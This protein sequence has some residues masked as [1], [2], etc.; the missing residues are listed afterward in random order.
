MTLSIRRL[1]VSYARREVLHSLS[2]SLEEGEITALIGPNGAGKSTLIKAVSGVVPSK[3]EIFAGGQNLQ[4]VSRRA[5]A[6]L[7]AVV[8]QMAF[9]PPHFTSWQTVMLGRTPYLNFLGH[10]SAKDEA[11]VRRALEQVDALSLA[12]TPVGNLSGGERQRVLLARALAQETPI[13]LLDEP[14]AHLDLKYQ[15]DILTLVRDLTRM[16]RLSVLLAIHD[17][18]LAAQYADKVALLVEGRIRAEGTP[19]EVFHAGTIAEAYG[20]PVEVIRHPES[21]VP[22][23]VSSLWTKK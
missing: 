23:V 5:R 4:A 20:L 11:I 3:G 21:N 8:P 14:T 16:H 9:L 22:L 7:V 12:K 19:Q 17:L 10:F 13:L 1:S 15:V 6:R 2:L 18:N